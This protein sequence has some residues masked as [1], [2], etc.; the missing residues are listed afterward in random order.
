MATVT[1]RTSDEKEIVMP[2]KVAD[3]MGTI[4]AMLSDMGDV[5][6][7]APTPVSVTADVM[8]KVFAFCTHHL[9]DAEPDATASVQAVRTAPVGDWDAAFCDVP[10]PELFALIL[11]A[12]YLDVKPLLDAT[13]GTVAASLAGKTPAEIREV[14]NIK[15]DFTPEEEAQVLRENAWC[16]H[17]VGSE[18]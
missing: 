4:R 1:V 3:M 7:D 6:V 18:Q 17:V 15:N 9:D 2:R 12:N 16:A 10:Q 14:F 5:A 13:C 8:E 11:A